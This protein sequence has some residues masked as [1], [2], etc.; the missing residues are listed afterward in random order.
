VI[1]ARFPVRGRGLGA[2]AW[3]EPRPTA[4][5]S[6]LAGSL[7]ALGHSFLVHESTK[8]VSSETPGREKGPLDRLSCRLS[9]IRRERNRFCSMGFFGAT[10]KATAEREHGGEADSGFRGSRRRRRGRGLSGA[11]RRIPLWPPFGGR[12]HAGRWLVYSSVA[13]GILISM[14]LTVLLNV[15]VCFFRQ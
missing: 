14:V 12:R 4:P 15:F 8:G 6:L 3:A 13:T 1:R 11:E 9:G 10:M 7:L 2:T 5:A